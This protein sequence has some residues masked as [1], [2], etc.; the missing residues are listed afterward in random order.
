MNAFSFFYSRTQSDD[1]R[2]FCSPPNLSQ[3]ETSKLLFLFE[4]YKG[5]EISKSNIFVELSSNN[6]LSICRFINTQHKDRYSRDI[7]AIQGYT[8]SIANCE[9]SIDETIAFFYYSDEVWVWLQDTILIDDKNK[10]SELFIDSKK[11]R[12]FAHQ[13]Q[14]VQKLVNVINNSICVGNWYRVSANNFSMESYPLLLKSI[15]IPPRKEGLL[16][17]F[18]SWLVGKRHNVH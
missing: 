5:K 2:W 18:I 11:I 12:L 13:N 7:Y 10:P 17:K 8:F 9:A 6:N 1:Y 15:G 4:M 3:Q 14:K 16:R